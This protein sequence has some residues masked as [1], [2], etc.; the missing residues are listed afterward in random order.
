MAETANAKIADSETRTS[1][2][3]S[4]VLWG[5]RSLGA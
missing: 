5:S 4:Y 1:W 3:R 2:S